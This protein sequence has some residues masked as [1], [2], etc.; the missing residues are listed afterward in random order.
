MISM[1]SNFPANEAPIAKGGRVALIK[2][3]ATN[4]RFY[5]LVPDDSEINNAETVDEIPPNCWLGIAYPCLE[6]GLNDFA[7]I[8]TSYETLELF[9]DDE[10]MQRELREMILDARRNLVGRLME[11]LERLIAQKAY[12]LGADLDLLKNFALDL[13]ERGFSRREL[14]EKMKV[15]IFSS[16]GAAQRAAGE[17]NSDVYCYQFSNSDTLSR[18]RELPPREFLLSLFAD[19]LDSV[20]DD[21]NYRDQLCFDRYVFQQFIAMMFVSYAA[22]N[23][24]FYGTHKDDYGV[25]HDKMMDGTPLYRAIRQ[26][27]SRISAQMAALETSKTS[28]NQFVDHQREKSLDSPREITESPSEFEPLNAQDQELLTAPLSMAPFEL[29][30]SFGNEDAL[31]RPI[32][33]IRALALQ[34]QKHRPN[35]A[36]ELSTLILNEA[37][38]LVEELKRLGIISPLAYN[39]GASESR[40]S[41]DASPS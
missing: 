38:R 17:S 14:D 36:A 11:L 19:V 1:N 3:L 8:R 27:L 40:K 26:E 5:V 12:F 7:V 24:V 15:N 4:N 33:S 6:D 32:A 10:D 16:V 39:P 18:L 20:L 28:A 31:L 22:T 13:M 2:S 25:S 9:S 21:E 23:P 30:S 37:T 41:D 35:D 34:L 29:P